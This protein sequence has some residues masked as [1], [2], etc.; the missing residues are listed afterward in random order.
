MKTWDEYRHGFGDVS[1]E[2]WLGNDN[3][4]AI[5]SSGGRFLLRIELISH[6]GEKRIAEYSDFSLDTAENYYKL[7]LGKYVSRSDA[8]EVSNNNVF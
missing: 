4:H 1:N 3:I 5:T 6:D 8:G 7:H 2:F